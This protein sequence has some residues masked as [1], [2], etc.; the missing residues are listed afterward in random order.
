MEG[1]ERRNI[2]FSEA[3][4]SLNGSDLFTELCLSCEIAHQSLHSLNDLPLFSE[5]GVFLP[6]FLLRRIP[7]PKLCSEKEKV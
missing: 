6:W 3:G 5:G 1:D 7:C 2:D 4:G